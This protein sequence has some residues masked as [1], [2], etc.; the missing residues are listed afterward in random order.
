MTFM[1]YFYV[2]LDLPWLMQ[3]HNAALV[4]GLYTSNLKYV[5]ILAAF[6]HMQ[7]ALQPAKLLP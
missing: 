6:P 7:A 2:F 1:K 3:K 5:V 4:L